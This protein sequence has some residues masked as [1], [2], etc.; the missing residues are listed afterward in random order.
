MPRTHRLQSNN[1]VLGQRPYLQSRSHAPPS[2]RITLVCQR[3]TDVFV[4]HTAHFP[5][6]IYCRLKDRKKSPPLVCHR[7]FRCNLRS[8]YVDRPLCIPVVLR[9]A[10]PRRCQC[11]TRNSRFAGDR[12]GIMGPQSLARRM[13]D[14]WLSPGMKCNA[15]MVITTRSY[16]RA[17]FRT[18]VTGTLR[19]ITSSKQ[20]VCFVG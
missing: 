7:C 13:D 20:A 12:T 3:P 8:L 5:V 10:F 16:R 19:C 6:S 11:A 9:R 1:E 2:A 17:R 4:S 14:Q 15:K 18:H